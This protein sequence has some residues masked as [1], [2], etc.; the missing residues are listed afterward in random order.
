MR[1]TSRLG[2]LLAL[3][4]SPLLAQGKSELA[5]SAAPTSVNFSY[6]GTSV[7]SWA[8]QW[9]LSRLYN[10]AVGFELGMFGVLPDGTR[11]LAR[12]D[13][14]DVGCTPVTWPEPDENG[15]ALGCPEPACPD[16]VRSPDMIYGG[17]ASA[18]VRIGSRLRVG[19]GVGA[20]AQS[21][22]VGPSRR[23]TE[24]WQAGVDVAVLRAGPVTLTASARVVTLRV[25]LFGAQRLFLPGVG[26]SF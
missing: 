3:A 19:A 6:L 12:C 4:A 13:G 22:S 18:F 24:A 5:F 23:S 21:G 26:L 10:R 20:V 9:R 1:L 17:F 16:D 11:G 15:I 7:P 2:A 8:L 14:S 25:P